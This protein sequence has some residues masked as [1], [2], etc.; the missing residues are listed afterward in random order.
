MQPGAIGDCILTLSLA[1]FMKDCLQLG[2][3]DILGHT[4]YIGILPGRTCIDS[5]RSMDSM[6]LHRLFVET[7]VFDLQVAS[8]NTKDKYE[9]RVNNPQ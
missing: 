3:I 9:I 8:G 1:E 4:E 2:G 5:V 6:N 7:S